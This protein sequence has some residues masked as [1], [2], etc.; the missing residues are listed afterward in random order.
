MS[1]LTK[2][3]IVLL[4]VFSIAFTTMTV[5]IV[6]QWANWKELAEDY[7]QH[8]VVADTNLRHMI[9]ANA[10]E[11]AAA[12]DTIV[13]HLDQ[14]RGLEGQLQTSRNELA[15]LRSDLARA[16]SEKSSSEAINRGLVAQLQSAEAGREGYRKQRD[17]LE[18]R[19]IELERRNIDLNDR[20][21][22]LTARV[23]VMLEQ[24]RQLEQQ[25]NIVRAENEKLARTARQPSAAI[26]MED[27]A[28]AAMGRITAVS[29]AATSPVRGRVLE[30]SGDIVTISVGEA[31]GVRKD[32]V[33]VVHRDDRYIRDLEITL[34]DA[35]QA[36]GRLVGSGPTP[37]PGD[38]V[39]D[40]IGLGSTR[41]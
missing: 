28:G 36:A 13:G 5:S 39:T 9:A 2:V 1:T 10:A 19:G 25:I 18:H 20:V 33:F 4:S 11:L 38:Q 31:D 37:R 17:D 14:I 3:F 27:A 6:A 8:A 12:N 22:E 23:V 24:K 30:I 41:G 7:Q 32:M 34:V 21:N 29:P 35:N 15:Q 16:A 40:A 26:A